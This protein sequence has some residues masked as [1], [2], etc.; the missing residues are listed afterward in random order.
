MGEIKSFKDLIAWQKAH[1]FV[2]EIY[3]ITEKFP[4]SEKFG[5]VTQMR[6][7]AVSTASNIVE[8]FARE[9]IQESLQFFNIANASLEEVKYQLLVSKDINLISRDE[10]ENVLSFGEEAGKVLRGWIKSQRVENNI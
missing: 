4:D 9:K 1:Q 2:I 5:L 10:Y 3:K 7:A 8:G 6:R